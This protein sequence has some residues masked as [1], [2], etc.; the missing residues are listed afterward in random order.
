LSFSAPSKP[1]GGQSRDSS[2]L[3]SR[4][5]VGRGWWPGWLA[6]PSSSVPTDDCNGKDDCFDDDSARRSSP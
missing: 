6:V 1:E 3:V 5:L 2:E 4:R